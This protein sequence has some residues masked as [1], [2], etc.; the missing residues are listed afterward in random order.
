MAVSIHS[1]VL[2]RLIWVA[3]DVD[4]AR[5]L[6]RDGVRDPI[7]FGQEI[8]CIKKFKADRGNEAIDQEVIYATMVKDIFP[9]CEIQSIGPPECPEQSSKDRYDPSRQRKK[10]AKRNRR[11]DN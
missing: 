11:Q 3:E 9:G 10:V 2:G 1:K 7:Y 4:A 8:D 6:Y 5:E